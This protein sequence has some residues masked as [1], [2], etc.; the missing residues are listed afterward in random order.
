M[1]A[2][3]LAIAAAVSLCALSLSTT[4]WSQPQRPDP[5]AIAA[6]QKAANDR[7]EALPRQAATIRQGRLSGVVE[8]GVASFRG[9]PYAAAPVGDLRWRAPKARPALERRARR[10]PAPAIRARPKRTAFI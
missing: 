9:I 8:N 4:V 7:L 2:K 5:A 1:I 10:G 6:A 3:R